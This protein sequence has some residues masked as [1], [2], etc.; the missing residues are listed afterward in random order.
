MKV[1]TH[2]IKFWTL[3][4]LVVFACGL[5]AMGQATQRSSQAPS[6]F[7]IRQA[8]AE[9]TKKAIDKTV[10]TEEALAAVGKIADGES[11]DARNAF[12]A[13]EVANMLGDTARAIKIL[14]RVVRE[15]PEAKAPRMNLPVEILGKLWIGAYARRAGDTATAESMYKQVLERLDTSNHPGVRKMPNSM[16]AM[17]WLYLAEIETATRKRPDKAKTFLRQILESSAPKNSQDA[18][19]LDFYKRWAQHDLDALLQ[20]DGKKVA[21]TKQ[22]EVHEGL[23][24]V[25]S[26]SQLCLSGLGD[27]SDLASAYPRGGLKLYEESLRKALPLQTSPVDKSMAQYTLGYSLQKRGKFA[28]ADDLFTDLFDSKSP[29][30]PNGGIA[31]AR[32]QMKQGKIE[33]AK[34]TLQKVASKFESRKEYVDKLLNQ[35]FTNSRSQQS[36]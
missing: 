8:L 23:D 9:V 34:Q 13:A 7:Q 24:L 30:A 35:K 1:S 21:S 10:S 28:E 4:I 20:A 17:C 12:S 26:V 22:Q 15:Q 19:L 11:L 14:K 5:P 25:A 36:K 3:A 29:L 2:Q 6:P 16:R 33:E 31:L 18:Q 27:A 32:C